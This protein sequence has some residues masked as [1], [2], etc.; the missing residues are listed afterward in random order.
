MNSPWRKDPDTGLIH[1]GW[2]ETTTLCGVSLSSEYQV[3]L[4]FSYNIKRPFFN[5]T[6]EAQKCGCCLQMYDDP[7]HIEEALAKYPELFN[8]DLPEETEWQP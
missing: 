5:I 6:F 7:E 3:H 2:T 8:Y 1:I 4:L